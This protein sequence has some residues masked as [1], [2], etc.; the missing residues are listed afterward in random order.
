MGLDDWESGISKLAFESRLSLFAAK[1]LDSYLLI[2][3]LSF[4]YCQM[5]RVTTSCFSLDMW[6]LSIQGLRLIRDPGFLCQLDYL[7]NFSCL[8]VAFRRQWRSLQIGFSFIRR[9]RGWW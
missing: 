4:L 3:C 8:F 6:Q 2:L 1:I 7:K 9:S 5:G